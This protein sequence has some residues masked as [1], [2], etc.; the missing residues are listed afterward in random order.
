ME[1]LKQNTTRFLSLILAIIVWAS[2]SGF[3]FYSHTCSHSGA[4]NHSL[5]IPAEKSEHATIES[6]ND[7]CCKIMEE[8]SCC[9]TPQK[10]KEK[11][12]DCCDDQ[13]EFK[14]LDTQTLVSQ[15]II[16]LKSLKTL[17]IEALFANTFLANSYKNNDFDL[18]F[19][20]WPPPKSTLQFLSN[21]QVYII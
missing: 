14:K 10:E 13:K 8:T 18:S 5:F 19:D 9:E 15:N 20:E 6:I 3:S 17:I 1:K 11:T 4:K 21:I 16:E 2:S 12:A 7:S